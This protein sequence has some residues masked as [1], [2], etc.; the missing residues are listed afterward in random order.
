VAQAIAS[1]LAADRSYQMRRRVLRRYTWQAVLERDLLPLL[2]E[3]VQ[4][5]E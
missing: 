5:P 2:Q 3:V 1:R 4:R